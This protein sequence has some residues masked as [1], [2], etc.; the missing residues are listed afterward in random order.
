MEPTDLKSFELKYELQCRG[1]VPKD[2]VELC[3]AQLRGLLSKGRKPASSPCTFADDIAELKASLSELLLI[4]EDSEIMLDKLSLRRIYSRFAHV[5]NRLFLL[6]PDDHDEEKIK[7]ELENEFCMIQGLLF[8]RE[9]ASEDEVKQTTDPITSTPTL[10]LHSVITSGTSN[11]GS[12]PNPGPSFQAGMTHPSPHVQTSVNA[13]STF[14]PVTSNSCKS[15]PVFKWN[16]KF[17]GQTQKEGLLSFLEKVEELC[18][19]RNISHSELFNSAIDL[20][21]G[22]A[23]LWFRNIR[24]K[25]SSWEELVECLRKDF[26]P[27]DYEYDIRVEILSRTQGINENVIM[28]IMSVESL[29]RRLGKNT[30]ESEITKQIIR[31]LN[32][33]YSDRISSYEIASLDELKEKCRKIHEV[34]LRNERYKPPPSRKSGLLEPEMACLS[35]ESSSHNQ[36][37][38]LSLSSNPLAGRTCWNCDIEGHPYSECLEPRRLFC[39]GCG[40]KNTLKSACTECSAKNAIGGVVPRGRMTSTFRPSVGPTPNSQNQNQSVQRSNPNPRR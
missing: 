24:P 6:K 7:I 11:A 20:F 3:R 26:L 19:A 25:I 2:K 22:Q 40:R 28:Y 10:S 4:L 5:E 17:S 35:L 37:S 33:F 15:V 36:P 32:P 16:V 39:Y 23:L 14:Q 13:N 27:V 21:T 12:S 9:H 1:V 29:F 18:I 8:Y 34:K 30:S 38:L 31:N